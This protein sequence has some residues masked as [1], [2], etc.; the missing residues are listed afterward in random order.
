MNYM[1]I[2]RLRCACLLFVVAFA[3]ATSSVRNAGAID[4]NSLLACRKSAGLVAAHTI[5]VNAIRE[6]IDAVLNR[7][8]LLLSHIKHITDPSWVRYFFPK[9]TPSLAEIASEL[10]RLQQSYLDLTE[11]LKQAEA[12]LAKARDWGKSNCTKGSAGSN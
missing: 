5:K 2:A 4:Y 8:A 3:T 6:E 1:S 9:E 12:N 10:A 7:T 11:R